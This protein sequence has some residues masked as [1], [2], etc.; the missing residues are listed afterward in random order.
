MTR[1]CL[2]EVISS[3]SSQVALPGQVAP[4][5]HSRRRNWVLTL[6]CGHARTATTYDPI[7]PRKVSCFACQALDLQR[8]QVRIICRSQGGYDP[9]LIR[10]LRRE[11]ILD[12]PFVSLTDAKVVCDW[13]EEHSDPRHSRL[14]HMVVQEDEVGRPVNLFD[15]IDVSTD[16]V[17]AFFPEGM[18]AYLFDPALWPAADLKESPARRKRKR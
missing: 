17:S 16:T 4:L 2:R 7:P 5:A 11:W 12:R 18:Y 10:L 8:Q 15:W 13:L 14:R 3:R 1:R 6:T 9:E